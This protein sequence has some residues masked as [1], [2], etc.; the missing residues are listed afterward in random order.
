MRSAGLDSPPVA[1]NPPRRPVRRALANELNRVL[2]EGRA[3]R[4]PAGRRMGTRVSPAWRS[5]WRE[6][7]PVRQCR[8]KHQPSSPSRSK[9]SQPFKPDD[10]SLFLPALRLV[11][12]APAASLPAFFSAAFW[13]PRRLFSAAASLSSSRQTS[14]KS[15]SRTSSIWRGVEDVERDLPCSAA[16]L[17]RAG[18]RALQTAVLQPAMAL[19]LPDRQDVLHLARNDRQVL[20]TD[21]LAGDRFRRG[22]VIVG[23]VLRRA[24]HK[25]TVLDLQELALR[26]GEMRTHFEQDSSCAHGG[27]ECCHR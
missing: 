22:L 26:E 12:L 21:E 3:P 17:H 13:A 2:R 18:A 4:R 15:R 11:V 27:A 14:G 20:D 25:S 8:E 16:Q 24:Q 23:V 7:S 10:A 1:Y 5:G 9:S 19:R 6:A